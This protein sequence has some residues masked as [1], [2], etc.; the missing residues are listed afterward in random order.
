MNLESA[1]ANKILPLKPS[2]QPNPTQ[3]ITVPLT[4]RS[5]IIYLMGDNRP[6]PYV[7]TFNFS[8]QHELKPQMTLEVSYVGTKGT[9]LYHNRELNETNIFENGFL[10]AFNVTRA[11]GTAPLFD[12]MLSGLNVPGAGVVKAA[13]LNQLDGS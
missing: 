10:D 7:Q 8:L 13:L 2:F 12:Q 5:Q 1:V 6:T 9:H 3:S 11:G 4:D